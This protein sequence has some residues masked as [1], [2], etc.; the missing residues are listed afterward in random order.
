[1]STLR[2]NPIQRVQIKKPLQPVQIAGRAQGPKYRTA[3]EHM[4]RTWQKPTRD[5]LLG[6]LEIALRQAGLKH[7]GTGAGG[8]GREFFGWCVY[9]YVFHSY[10]PAW[11]MRRI[12]HGKFEI[13]HDLK[14]F[15]ILVPIQHEMGLIAE[16]ASPNAVI[17]D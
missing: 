7:I 5:E 16:N 6:N 17:T 14:L 4:L 10:L 13:R 8:R 9:A 1:M 12:I 2:R 3:V 15:A 11:M